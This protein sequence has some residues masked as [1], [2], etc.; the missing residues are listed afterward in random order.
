MC[1]QLT[2]FLIRDY[3]IVISLIIH[4]FSVA[5]HCTS[6]F[7]LNVESRKDTSSDNLIDS[8]PLC[9]NEVILTSANDCRKL[10][11]SISSATLELFWLTSARSWDNIH[12][13]VLSGIHR[14]FAISVVDLSSFIRFAITFAR[15][16]L[17]IRLPFIYLSWVSYISYKTLF[18]AICSAFACQSFISRQIDLYF[19]SIL[20]GIS[21]FVSEQ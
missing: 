19:C 14:S 3:S 4:T 15:V 11:L 10:F 16:L 7:C 8:S 21:I 13:T 17:S 9:N 1:N 20:F 2:R 5:F 18:I 6:W 12:L